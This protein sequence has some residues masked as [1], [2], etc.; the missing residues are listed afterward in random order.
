MKYIDEYRDRSIV[1]ALVSRIKGKARELE[2]D[3]SIMEVCGTHTNAIGRFGIRGMLPTN[4]RLISGPGCPVCVTSIHDIDIA[5]YLAGRDDV[6]F[7]TFGD[8]LRVPGT[9]GLNLQ[10]LR[11][12][13]ADVRIVTSPVDCIPFCLANPLKKVVF[14]G[15]GFETTSP[16]VSALILEAKRH[17]LRNLFVFSVHK[18]IPPAIKLLMDD[19]ELNIDGFICP[20][21]VST[22]IGANAY[23]FIAESSK[24]AVV[25]GFEPVD[26]LE[27]ILMILD[28]VLDSEFRV[29]IQ[30]TR[31][32]KPEGNLKAKKVLSDVFTP[33]DTE[34]RG[35]GS[36]EKSGLAFRYVYR[37]FDVTRAFEIP[38][39]NSEEFHGCICADILKGYSTPVECP[40]FKKVCTP[41]NPVGPCMV[42]SEGTCAAYYRYY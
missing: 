17:G 9:G 28:Q 18:L 8:M 29:E 33:C 36:I 24:A 35:L 34:W 32:V 37:E 2:R 41:L 19:P 11:A 42:S 10:Q 21:H 12:R 23:R 15:I 1:E 14:M 4:I 26:I 3:I 27:G 5:L 25:T 38:A 22:I 31:A 20:G 13:G 6:I 39:I 16:M 7:A 30:Y 40:L